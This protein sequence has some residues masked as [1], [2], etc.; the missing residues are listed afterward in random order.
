MNSDRSTRFCF[1]LFG[2]WENHEQSEAVASISRTSKG[3]S[4]STMYLGLSYKWKQPTIYLQIVI[5]MVK[6]TEFMSCPLFKLKLPY[7][8][9]GEVV[10]S[11][12]VAS[13]IGWASSILGSNPGLT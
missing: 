13:K 11:G 7:E 12:I 6:R 9:E 10:G 3:C 1:N 5:G 8:Y 2:I 4:K